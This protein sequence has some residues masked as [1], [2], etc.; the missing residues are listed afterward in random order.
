MVVPAANENFFL[1]KLSQ[2]N[3]PLF[4]IG[5]SDEKSLTSTAVFAS[6]GNKWLGHIEELFLFHGSFSRGI[7]HLRPLVVSENSTGNLSES[8]SERTNTCRCPSIPCEE[9]FTQN[10][11]LLNR[12]TRLLIHIKVISIL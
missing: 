10:R 11:N 6:V 5:E 12:R 7:S 2:P 8:Q 9:I 4:Q 3:R 1:S